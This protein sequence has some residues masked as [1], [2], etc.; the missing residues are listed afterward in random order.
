MENWEEKRLYSYCD[1]EAA[2]FTTLTINI[3][4]QNNPQIYFLLN[5]STFANL[6][7]VCAINM[8]WTWME[9]HIH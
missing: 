2:N 4:V 9:H 5:L 7:D 3:K 1:S 8:Q 6:F